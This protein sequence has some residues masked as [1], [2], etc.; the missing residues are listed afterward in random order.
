MAERIGDAFVEV[1]ADISKYQKRMGI[2]RKRFTKIGA[3]LVRMGKRAGLAFG[4]ALAAG[5][6]LA[7]K[8][9]G[10]QERAEKDLESALR[11]HGDAVDTLFPKFKEL[12]S[13]IQ[14][15]TTLGDEAVLSMMAQIRN[16]G[17]M[18]AQMEK[19]TKGAIGLGKALGLD[20][21]AAARYSAL[22]IAGEYTI[23]QR[24]V[25]AL[26]TA[27]SE[28]EKQAIVTDLMR[29]GYEQAQA[30]TET[31]Q[32]AFKSLRN[33]VGDLF[34]QFGFMIFQSVGVRD[35]LVK[36]RDKTTEFIKTIKELRDTDFMERMIM[37][38]KLTW[39]NFKTNFQK[40]WTIGK[41]TFMG[42]WETV[43]WVFESI[44]KAVWNLWAA[45]TKRFKGGFD[46]IKAMFTALLNFIKTGKFEMPQ[47]KTF[48]DEF[49][50]V[51]ATL[52]ELP[53]KAWQ[54]MSDGLIEIS[55]NLAADEKK[56]IDDFVKAV[57]AKRS[58]LVNDEIDGVKKGA[59]AVED[60]EK[61]KR[62]ATGVTFA[63]AERWRK[64]QEALLKLKP[65]KLPELLEARKAVPPIP[66]EE[67][68][69]WVQTLMQKPPPIPGREL[70]PILPREPI[71]PRAEMLTP[72][73]KEELE[74]LKL[75]RKDMARTEI[76]TREPVPIFG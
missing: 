63:F 65:P 14:G 55:Q 67:I 18:P 43:K 21:A 72:W 62:K 76:N 44:G 34:E 10:T 1:T 33:S 13:A 7:V 74:L 17:V 22:A 56:I 5:V 60:A 29:K 12:A 8:A 3:G 47:L 26:R 53:T 46:N 70:I 69:L 71:Q 35:I 32:G 42:I 37:Q 50:D 57:K 58:E 40:I 49:K 9:A 19:A 36:L 66:R 39:L 27:T 73:Q 30:E 41:G 23:L 51:F 28:A 59:A 24:Y 16:L 45:V 38:V 15:Q 68:P 48:Q 4:A 31:V 25:P 64:V 52:P 11:A 61:R 20:A 2:V 6:A 75:I 54:E